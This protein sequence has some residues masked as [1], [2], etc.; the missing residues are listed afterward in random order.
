MTGSGSVADVEV[1]FVN[2]TL[3]VDAYPAFVFTVENRGRVA[4]ESVRID[5]DA[6]RGGST[7]ASTVTT[8]N[9]LAPGEQAESEP[10]VLAQL[11]SHTDYQCYRYRVR[12]Y[13]ER[14]ET[15]SDTSSG[16]VCS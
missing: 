7:V 12:A 8:V 1:V 15:L 3:Y 4:V 5:V 9:D 2:R 10:A 16:Q 6:I 13:D 11:D 14:G